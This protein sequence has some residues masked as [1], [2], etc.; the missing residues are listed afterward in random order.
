[1]IKNLDRISDMPNGKSSTECRKGL[2]QCANKTT[3]N[4]PMP[5][6]KAVFTTL[7]KRFRQKAESL[8]LPCGNGKN[9]YNF[10]KK[11]IFFQG[12]R[13]TCGILFW[14]SCWT[15][16]NKKLKKIAQKTK[17]IEKIHF[18]QKNSIKKFLGTHWIQFLQPNAFCSSSKMDR[19]KFLLSIISPQIFLPRGEM[20]FSRPSRKMPAGRPSFFLSKSAKELKIYMNF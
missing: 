12:F 20:H 16:F 4:H 19:E 3:Q 2:A 9:T 18:S 15:S 5:T 7:P 1:M 11:L 6:S 10:F 8:P 14:Q 17:I 13:W